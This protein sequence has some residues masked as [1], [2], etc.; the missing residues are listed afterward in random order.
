[1]E[2]LHDEDLQDAGVCMRDNIIS[3]HCSGDIA[4][5]LVQSCIWRAKI[6]RGQSKPQSL[7]NQN[8]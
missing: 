6:V 1:M 4:D 5:A 2:P 8:Y 7:H 3:I